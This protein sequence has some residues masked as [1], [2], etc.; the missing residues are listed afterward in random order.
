ME[1]CSNIISHQ[2]NA[3]QDHSKISLNAPTR[4]AIVKKKK[5]NEKQTT[6]SVDKDVEKVGL[7]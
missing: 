5:K 4:V 1:R 7:P 2:G 3:N 6:T